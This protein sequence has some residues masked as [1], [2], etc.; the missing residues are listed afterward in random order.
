MVTMG[1]V[2]EHM[3]IA[4]EKLFDDIQRNRA[5][6]FNRDSAS[7]IKGLPVAP[8]DAV[9]T[10]DTPK[11]GKVYWPETVPPWPEEGWSAPCRC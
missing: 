10:V 7:S 3:D 5:L 6:V 1:D 2:R 11:L 9:V 8:L 4:W